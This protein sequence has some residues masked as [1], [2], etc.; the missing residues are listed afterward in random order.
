MNGTRQH[1]PD[2]DIVL[3]D[4]HIPNLKGEAPDAS[5]GLSTALEISRAHPAVK[6]VMISADDKRDTYNMTQAYPGIDGFWTAAATRLEL[7]QIIELGLCWPQ[8]LPGAA[9]L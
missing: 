8:I 2:L 9:R 1:A 7:L 5:N 6:I 3:L 4:V